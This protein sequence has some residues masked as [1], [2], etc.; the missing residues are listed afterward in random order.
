MA[1]ENLEGFEWVDTTNATVD[2]MT[3]WN[4]YGSSISSVDMGINIFM[5]LSFIWMG[6]GLYVLAK[7]MNIKNAWM[8]W[9]PLLQYYTM[10]QV[11]NV[12]FKKYFLYP[13]LIIIAIAIIWGIGLMSLTW[14]ESIWTM[15]IFVWFIS[16][17]YIVA[18]I[19]SLVRYINILSATSKRTWRGG[20]TTAGLFFIPF[21][22]YPVV[23]LKYKEDTKKE[24]KVVE[25]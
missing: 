5:L 3:Y 19:Y 8:G 25:L 24:E 4:D 11:A 1:I 18:Y 15:V 6:Y 16:I 13:M 12:S 2:M 9:V 14:P 21:I 20:W 23:A 7:K 17:A 10:T 22:M